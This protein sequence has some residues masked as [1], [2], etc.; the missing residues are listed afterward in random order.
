MIA[1]TYGRRSNSNRPPLPRN[2]TYSNGDVVVLSSQETTSEELYDNNNN[3][4]QSFNFS[5][6]ESNSLWSQQDPFDFDSQTDPF[7]LDS[8]F[9]NANNGFNR[10]RQKNGKRDREVVLDRGDKF[11]KKKKEKNDNNNK[12]VFD[13]GTYMIP[14][15]STLMEAR[16]YGEMMEHV[17]EVNFALDGL[18][19][20]QQLRTRRSSLLSL[21]SICSTVQQR[22]LLRS[23]GMAKTIIDAIL[24]IDFDDSSS[25]LAAAAL[26]YA[27][28]W[29][30]Q[31]D[32]LLESPNSIRFLIKCLK[33]TT[34][35]A[36]EDKAPKIG[37]KLLAICRDSNISR[38]TS[39]MSDSTSAGILSKVQDILVSCKE[40]KSNRV[41]DSG[42]KRPEL[43]PIWIALLTMEKGCLSKISFE[44]TT[45]AVRKTGRKFKEKLRELGGLDAIFQVA[46]KCHSEM[47]VWLGR[48]STSVQALKDDSDLQTL[49]LLL[50][51][52]KILENATFL[53]EANQNRL[54]GMEENLHS[55][56][57]RRIT[58]VQ[59]VI[60]VIKILSG[61]YL[62]KNSTSSSDS[63][64]K[65]CS[66]GT[67]STSEVT[68]IANRK[69]SN[70]PIL[71]SSSQ[72]SSSMEL[73]SEERSFG[74]SWDSTWSS[75]DQLFLY[76]YFSEFNNWNTWKKNGPI[77]TSPGFGLVDMTN[78]SKD[79]K[80]DSSKNDSL[81][82]SQDPFAFDD[83][84][85]EPSKWDILSGNQKDSGP[86]K[87]GPK[88]R[89]RKERHEDPTMTSKIESGSRETCLQES[90]VEE[91][92]HPRELPR[93]STDEEEISSLLGDC[94]LTAV[95]VWFLMNLTNEN[96][97]GCQQIALCGGLETTASLIARH[98]PMFSSSAS[99]LIS[100]KEDN[101]SSVLNAQN[102]KHLTDEE[103][104]FLVAI[105]GLLVNLV[106]KDGQNRSQLA[107]TTVSLC[108][109]EG[110]R[111]AESNVIPLLC[112][113]FIAN[114]GAGDTV[115]EG[116]ELTWNDEEAVLQGEK[117]AEKM[118][119]EA[120][121]AL[122]LAFL[123]TESE[124]I[125]D[126]ITEWLP[127][128]SLKIL[129]P[130]LERFVAFHLTLE[131][132]TPETHKAVSEVIESCKL[133]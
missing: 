79:T 75:T 97:I 84:N 30:G 103:L 43:D 95:K 45:G 61:Q 64:P 93:S 74:M 132:I 109:S 116:N 46:L 76:W 41:F 123:S 47:E 78:S 111:V 91:V 53:S 50:K 31:D 108:N 102:D 18:R 52:L 35:V 16:E 65:F 9:D 15:T 110:L 105:L 10:K 128:H 66:N 5:S 57:S 32:H 112:S 27:L 58:F 33:P 92:H 19:K 56:G 22:R 11:K 122:L 40:L 72:A 44:D 54:L 14:A 101:A 49:A 7:D 62:L 48:S 125:R 12:K 2:S 117:E 51:C 83:Y 26:F 67:A 119:V 80:Y 130:V 113:I 68:L 100:G 104:D 107:A 60:S 69:V 98:F 20:G 1:R 99:S 121:S 96:P 13:S 114:R 85:F 37:S 55:Y 39:R 6:Q 23:Q 82:D 28:T 21:L 38:G 88:R 89:R 131:M 94:L 86:Q 70:E 81:M 133:P 36:T 59:L 90:P 115:G 87:N 63:N 24:G 73:A 17:D 129:V 71:I 118:I 106:E 42:V 8:Q 3:Y 77:K 127:K 4:N 126:A 124:C 29:D 25:N 34:S 120:Y